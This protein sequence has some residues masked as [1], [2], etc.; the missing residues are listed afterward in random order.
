M[1]GGGAHDRGASVR[2]LAAKIPARRIPEAVERLI[3]LYA[4]EREAGEIGD[5]VLRPRRARR[6]QARAA[7]LERLPARRR[8]CRPTSSISAEASEFAPEVH[9][10]RVLGL[11]HAYVD[12][13]ISHLASLER[14]GIVARDN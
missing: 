7:D 12:A 1:V 8:A 6:R 11:N 13:S 14:F 9:G 2:R 3:A 5:G 4:R 10:R